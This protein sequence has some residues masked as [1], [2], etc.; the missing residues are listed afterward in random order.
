M[1]KFRVPH[2]LVLMFLMMI[3]ALVLTWL[4][5]AGEFNRSVN[6]IGQTV[7]KAGTYSEL[8]E[9][10][11]LTPITLLTVVPQALADAQGVIFFVLLIGGTMGI[12]RA[13][14]MLDA[15]IGVLLRH[16]ADR[17]SWL[18]VGGM[19]TFGIFSALIGVAEEYLIFV[20][21]LVALCR[22]LKLDAITALGIL[23]VGY[24]IG[25]GLSLFNPF[26]LLIAQAVA[27]VPPASG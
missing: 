7:V 16:F 11:W 4:I 6:E 3:A 13:T 1:V 10:P 26:T 17:T 23:I 9:Q 21:M 12:L 25:Y 8:E 24:G 5:P 20:P 19:L 18:I 14:G 15:L 27:E 22:A 2:T